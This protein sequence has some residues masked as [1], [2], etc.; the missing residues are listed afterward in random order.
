MAKKKGTMPDM[1]FGG[2]RK[3]STETAQEPATN[4]T[5]AGQDQHAEETG[6]VQVSTRIDADVANRARNIVWQERGL[7]LAALVKE[8]LERVV[9]EWEEKNGGRAPQRPMKDLPTGRPLG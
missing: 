7:T 3:S 5:Q 1:E 8:G 4:S 6:L 9:K 2:Q